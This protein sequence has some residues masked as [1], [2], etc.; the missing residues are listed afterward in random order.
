LTIFKK[1]IFK[2]K[3][4]IFNIKYLP[5]FSNLY[6]HTISELASKSGPR[7]HFNP[8]NYLLIPKWYS[9]LKWKKN[10]YR[11]WPTKKKL[12]ND[13][14]CEK[15]GFNIFLKLRITLGT[16]VCYAIFN[17]NLSWK[18]LKALCTY[19][20]FYNTYGRPNQVCQVIV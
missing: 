13:N 9:L 20:H 11:A 5:L 18:L 16:N 15:R 3:V 19:V 1:N 14:I 7:L 6:L 2:Y 10:F 4:F 17:R 8:L 12:K